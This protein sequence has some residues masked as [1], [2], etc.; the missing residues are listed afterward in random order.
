MSFVIEKKQ[1][2][3]NQIKSIYQI[4]FQFVFVRFVLFLNDNYEEVSEWCACYI[5][6]S[7]LSFAPT[8]DHSLVLD[9]P[10]NSSPIGTYKCLVEYVKKGELSFVNIITFNMDE[11]VCLPCDNSESYWSFM[12]RNLFGYSDIHPETST[13]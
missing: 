5:R 12:H 7:I 13:F 4:S 9:L 8:P 2:K 1:N 11:C 3:S 6:E 10:T